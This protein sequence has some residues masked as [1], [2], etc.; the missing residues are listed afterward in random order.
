MKHELA[1]IPAWAHIMGMPAVSVAAATPALSECQT[2]R[3]VVA[4]FNRWISVVARGQAAFIH[5]RP[6]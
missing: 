5:A 6:T 3:D 2:S 4:H 1:G